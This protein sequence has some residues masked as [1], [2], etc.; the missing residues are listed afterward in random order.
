MVSRQ[1]KSTVSH[2][3]PADERDCDLLE[4]VARKDKQ[5]FETLYINYHPR[6]FKF[7]F[8]M[9]HKPDVAEEVVNDVMFV[10]WQ[11]AE[12][13]NY[14]SK[15][16]TWLMGIAY[17]KGLEALRRLRRYRETS[18]EDSV[19]AAAA[20]DAMPVGGGPEDAFLTAE[21]TEQLSRN[22][23]ALGSEQRSVVELTALGYSCREIAGIVDC[24]VNTVKT[25]MFHAR[26]RLR[27][28]MSAMPA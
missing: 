1:K 13:F 16:S 24:P 17:R 22:V 15:V 6:L 4:R 20:M 9:V 10:A 11:R 28:S 3:I 5:A 7:L 18:I 8:R 19:E 23:D 2:A 25:R 21:F 26:R 27:E 14:K 12:T